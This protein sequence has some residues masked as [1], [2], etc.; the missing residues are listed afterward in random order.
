MKLRSEDPPAAP[1]DCGAFRGLAWRSPRTSS[2]LKP[3]AKGKICLNCHVTFQEK[4]KLPFVHTPVKAGD[5]S[6]CHNPHTSSHGKLLA[7]DVSKIC[8]SA[9][10]GSFPTRRKASTR[11]WRKGTA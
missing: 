3:G 9:T 10:T 5:C 8:L 4:L 7:A 6:G 1:C 2:D 11:S